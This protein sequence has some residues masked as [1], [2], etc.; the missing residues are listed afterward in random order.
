M[1]GSAIGARILLVE[2]DGRERRKKSRQ[3]DER[4]SLPINQRKGGQEARPVE[5]KKYQ[6]PRSAQTQ[7]SQETASSVREMWKEIDNNKH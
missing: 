4:V 3:D 2:V 5:A 1:R 7:Q 6:H